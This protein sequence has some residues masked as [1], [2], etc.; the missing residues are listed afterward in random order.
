V[1]RKILEPKYFTGGATTLGRTYDVSPD[2]QRFIMIK[3]ADS[4]QLVQQIVV[5]QHWDEELRR[6]VPSMP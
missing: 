3:R 6:L 5:V 1:P 2:G 4:D